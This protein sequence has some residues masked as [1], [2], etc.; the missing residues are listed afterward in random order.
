MRKTR[1]GLRRSGVVLGSLI[2]K[3][4][5]GTVQS[6]VLGRVPRD[7]R[8]P[9]AYMLQQDTSVP[10]SDRQEEELNRMALKAYQLAFLLK[11]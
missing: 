10:S 9:A 1:Y 5:F 7:F 4:K 8:S 6:S 11:C 3:N 2:Y